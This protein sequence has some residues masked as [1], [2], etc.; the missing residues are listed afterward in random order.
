M[1]VVQ[2]RVNTCSFPIKCLPRRR[3][4]RYSGL[5]RNKKISLTYSFLNVKTIVMLLP[6]T[7]MR[8]AVDTH[9]NMPNFFW[10][11]LIRYQTDNKIFDGIK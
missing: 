2:S 8:F 10:I 4:L 9:E 5:Q 3:K 6:Q 1:T 7:N 11:S